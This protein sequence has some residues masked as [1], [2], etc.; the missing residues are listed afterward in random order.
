[1][2]VQVAVLFS[3][4]RLALMLLIDKKQDLSKRKCKYQQLDS[5]SISTSLTLKTSLI[6]AKNSPLLRSRILSHH[7]NTHNK[8]GILNYTIL[9]DCHRETVLTQHSLTSS[10][11]YT[12]HWS[13][14]PKTM[15]LANVELHPLHRRLVAADSNTFKPSTAGRFYFIFCFSPSI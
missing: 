13:I 1:M 6:H 12:K 10:G 3:L 7:V 15:S 9:L 11:T 8:K 5:I 14:Q 2:F 4:K